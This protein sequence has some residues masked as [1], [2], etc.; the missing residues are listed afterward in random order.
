MLY[1]VLTPFEYRSLPLDLLNGIH[2]WSLSAALAVYE[3]LFASATIEPFQ[4]LSSDSLLL[5][6]HVG[7]LVLFSALLSVVAHVLHRKKGTHLPSVTV[8]RNVLSYYL[9]LHLLVYGLDKVLGQ[10]FY[11]PEPN[12][13]FTPLGELDK[14]LLYWSTMA[15][16]RSYLLVTGVFESMCALLLWFRKTRYL[17][18]LLSLVAMAQVVLINFSFDIS[19][20]LHAT[21][22]LVI[23]LFIV[24]PAL[25]AL[26]QLLLG[27]TS[28]GLQWPKLVIEHPIRDSI[29]FAVFR[30]LAI[31]FILMEAGAPHLLAQEPPSYYQT[32][33]VGAYEV[34]HETTAMQE[35][36]CLFETQELGPVNTHRVF[37]HS[38]EYFIIQKDG[39]FKDYTLQTS[40]FSENEFL[41]DKGK[42]RLEHCSTPGTFVLS[43]QQ[44][45]TETQL[46]LL[47]KIDL[48]QLPLAKDEFHWFMDSYAR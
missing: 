6:V 11:F 13:L 48:S 27:H 31:F 20:K 19:V 33:V 23:A 37:F 46:F 36:P 42:L 10:Q 40:P 8:Y 44:N 25:K 12:T 43:W 26:F 32:H 18:G 34:L 7:N 41:L 47:R 28:V 15:S 16:S 14:D 5:Y 45:G 30:A 21:L 22:L 1:P 38:K 24:W 9:S 2:A 35:E 4:E 17:G 29:R 39:L 3:F